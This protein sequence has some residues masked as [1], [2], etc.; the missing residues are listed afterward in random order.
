MCA[1]VQQ[2]PSPWHVNLAPRR[3]LASVRSPMGLLVRL[4]RALWIFGLIFASYMIQL[5]LVRVFGRK[6][7][8][9]PDGRSK[10]VPRAWLAERRKRIDAKNAKRL[11]HGMLRLRGVYIKLGQV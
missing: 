6:W 11:L 2:R 3:M 10:E 4:V 5:G 7:E 9:L 8:R 1:S